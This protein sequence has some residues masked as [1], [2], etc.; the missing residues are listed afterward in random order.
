[1]KILVVEDSA[2]MWKLIVRSVGLSGG[3]DVE[4]LEAVDGMQA[5]A[6]FRPPDARAARND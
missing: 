6:A 1:M 3:K 4:V 5:P 2:I